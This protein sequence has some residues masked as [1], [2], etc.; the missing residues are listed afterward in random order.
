MPFT[1]VPETAAGT[2]RMPSHWS[3][4]PAQPP[5]CTLHHVLQALAELYSSAF[6]TPA[7]SSAS[8]PLS[9]FV[10]GSAGSLVDVSS[11]TQALQ[12]VSQAPVFQLSG[13]C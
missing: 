4:H 7:A 3:V 1:A 13:G 11:T 6:S 5:C 8:V 12:A 9:G 2:T 10:S